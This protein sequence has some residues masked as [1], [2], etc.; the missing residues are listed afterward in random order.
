MTPPYDKTP[1]GKANAPQKKC[2]AGGTRT[3]IDS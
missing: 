1:Q 2:E 3:F